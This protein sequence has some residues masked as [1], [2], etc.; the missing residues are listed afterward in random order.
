MD[1]RKID[2]YQVFLHLILLG[3]ATLVVM[4]GVE[5]GGLRGGASP[6]PSAGPAVGEMLRPIDARNLEGRD[7]RLAFDNAERET[8]LLVWTTTCPACQANLPNWLALVERFG[9]RYDFVGLS[10]DSVEATKS[11]VAARALPFEVFVATDPAAFKTRYDIAGV[12]ETIHAGR[13]G[14]VRGSWL[15]VLPKDFLDRGL[16]GGEEP[17]ISDLSRTGGRPTGF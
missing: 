15:G 13:D 5:N 2:G 14:Q 11:Y 6:P 3:L 8:V 16:M 10:L 9:E 1:F 17:R 12:P 7:V 4:L